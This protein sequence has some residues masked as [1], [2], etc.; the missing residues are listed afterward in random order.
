MSRLSEEGFLMSPT[1]DTV[2]PEHQIRSHLYCG[3]AQFRYGFLIVL[4][5]SLYD[6]CAV[7]QCLFSGTPPVPDR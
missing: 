4:V 1:F 2:V 6:E 5:L 7:H 3:T